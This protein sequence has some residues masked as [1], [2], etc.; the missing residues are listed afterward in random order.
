MLVLPLKENMTVVRDFNAKK[1]GV[2]LVA[3][4]FTRLKKLIK[5]KPGYTI[6][7]F[8]RGVVTFMYQEGKL[9]RSTDALG[10]MISIRSNVLRKVVDLQLQYA[11]TILIMHL[12]IFSTGYRE[13]V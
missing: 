3:S 9:G 13:I 2:S 4:S 5:E 12:K 7:S 10:K 6:I 11:R 8:V 1:N